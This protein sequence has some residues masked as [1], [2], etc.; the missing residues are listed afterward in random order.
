MIY[1]CKTVFVLLTT[2][3]T[4]DSSACMRCASVPVHFSATSYS[5][6]ARL[7]KTFQTQ[8]KPKFISLIE[9]KGKA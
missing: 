7:E 4:L 8:F 6:L 2:N 9:K 3:P 1:H 5:I